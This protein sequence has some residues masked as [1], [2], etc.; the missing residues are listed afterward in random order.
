MAEA[1][2]KTNE[3][4]GGIQSLERATAILDFVAMSARDVALGEISA[5]TGL[6]TSTA[7][8]LAKT[9]VALGLLG[10]DPE[11][12]RYRI[13]S[14]LFT[15]A[16]GAMNDNTLLALGFPI[17][18]RLSAETG[19]A[20][21]LAVRSRQEIVLVARTAASGMLQMSERTGGSRPPHATAI[22]KILLAY[23]PPD[24]RHDLLARLDLSSF[25]DRT[26]TDLQ[27][28]NIELDNVRARGLAYDRCE[29]D[30]DVCC[31]AMPVFDFST[32]C[33]AAIGI[34]GPVW[35]M[36]EDHI[37]AAMRHLEH[38]ACELS[39]ALGYKERTVAE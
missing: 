17:L 1:K 29:F 3:R 7:F 11:T 37:S 4:G 19:E 28:L 27:Q 31:V 38:G 25:T 16:A 6:H 35:R 22:G 12:R 34:S 30:N 20:A 9:L 36:T 2:Q 33:I 39:I 10:Q 14:R 18:E 8:H 23:M 32:R 5:R 13:G 26:I 24:K 21:H 15:L